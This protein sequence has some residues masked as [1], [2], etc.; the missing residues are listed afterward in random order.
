MN[1]WFDS[2]SFHKNYNSV[3]RISEAVSLLKNGDVGEVKIFHNNGF[4]VLLAKWLEY[5]AKNQ[6]LPPLAWD[7]DDA[8]IAKVMISADYYWGVRNIKGKV[9]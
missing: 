9:Y 7:T 3:K 6:T 5:E 1:L 4:G 2:K 8:D